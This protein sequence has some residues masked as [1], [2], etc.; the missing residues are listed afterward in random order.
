MPPL[1]NGINAAPMRLPFPGDG[2]R[3]EI[4]HEGGGAHSGGGVVYSGDGDGM[5]G[6]RAWQTLGEWFVDRFGDEGLELLRRGDV[7][8]GHG[9]IVDADYPYT[10]G[11]R[12][13][14]FRPVLDEPSEPIVLPIVAENERYVVIDKPHG[15]ATVPKGSHVAHSVLVA[16]RRQ[17]G[18]DLLVAAHRLDLETAGLVLLVKDPQWRGKYQLLFE[19]RKIR[20]T[21]YAVAPMI[22]CAMFPPRPANALADGFFESGQDSW[23]YAHSDYSEHY[24]ISEGEGRSTHLQWHS[25]LVLQKIDGHLPV[26]VLKHPG[27]DSA[28]TDVQSFA[29]SGVF[30]SC[31]QTPF[32]LEQP[33]YGERTHA[34]VRTGAHAVTDIVCIRQIESE[35]STA[36]PHALYAL[37]P[38]TGFTHQLRVAMNELGAP[39]CGDP[40]YPRIMSRDEAARRPYPLQLLAAELEFVDPVSG[41]PTRISSQQRLALA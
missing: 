2:G 19:R 4:L 14:V 38:H 8:A 23:P 22:D 35:D 29:E 7:L 15:M 27:A 13:W 5:S 26:H 9:K 34:L 30:T 11:E 37:Y 31:E 10:P 41:E 36:R 33:Y 12:I 28:C 1:R 21:Y 17:F 39:I 24:E 18:N 40:L 16:A 6:G 20:K 32:N 3:K 25:D